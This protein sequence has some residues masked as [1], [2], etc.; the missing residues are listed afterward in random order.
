MQPAIE[1][2]ELRAERA[3]TK[4][5]DA[6]KW[7]QWNRPVEIRALAAMFADPE[8]RHVGGPFEDVEPSMFHNADTKTA[9]NLL[10]NLD[11]SG[12]PATLEALAERWKRENS[13]NF[14]DRGERLIAA[15]KGCEP[16]RTL[17][18]QAALATELQAAQRDL[19]QIM[20]E[21]E[22]AERDDLTPQGYDRARLLR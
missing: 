5:A 17:R 8:G 13:G 2:S 22:I 12:T 9:I 14:Y 7:A 16:E 18:G 20:G 1:P 10:R 21:A 6:A 15:I 11:A 19:L 4:P 3:R